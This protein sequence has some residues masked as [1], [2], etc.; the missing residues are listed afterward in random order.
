VLAHKVVRAGFY[1]PNMSK[2]SKAIIRNC[3]KCQRFAN[4]TKQPPEQLTSISSPWLFSQWRVDIVGPLPQGKGG[5]RFAV[6][7]VDYFTKWAEVEPLVN[8]T[9]KTIERFLWKNVVYRYS[10]PHAF[11]TNNGKQFDCEPF[12]K[13]FAKLYI[14][15]YFS[16]RRMGK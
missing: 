16:Y 15:N 2:D 14:R 12:R 4:I 1:W 5:V 9:A 3:N 8:I 10:V 6:V 13:W 11:V 7:A